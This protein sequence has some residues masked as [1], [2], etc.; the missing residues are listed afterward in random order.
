MYTILYY[1]QGNVARSIDLKVILHVSCMHA[2]VIRGHG[3]LVHAIIHDCFHVT[4]RE[5]NRRISVLISLFI[6]LSHTEKERR[7]HYIYNCNYE[8]YC[9]CFYRRKLL[10]GKR[11]WGSRWARKLPR[12]SSSATPYGW[13]KGRWAEPC[14]RN[15]EYETHTHRGG[16]GKAR[17]PPAAS[18]Y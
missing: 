7:T 11:E 16:K 5:A 2:W 4:Q 13:V 14:M 15:W 8:N 18:V 6:T 9:C 1:T 17:E 10:P 3:L 12:A